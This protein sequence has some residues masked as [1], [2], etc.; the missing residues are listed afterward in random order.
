MLIYIALGANTGNRRGALLQA[1]QALDERIGPLVKC[2]SFYETE[3][4]D[5]ESEHLFLNA[6]AIFETS[7][8][9]IQLLDI[10]QDI[11]REMGRER[12]S[13]GGVH[14]DRCIDIDLLMLDRQQLHTP[15]LTLPHPHMH[16]RLFVLEPLAEIAPDLVHP[17]LGKTVRE[18]LHLMRLQQ[19][20]TKYPMQEKK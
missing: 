12:K 1:L 2:S 10:T 11:E 5:F 6:A 15:R 3:P 20:N 7:L 19:I 14:Y 13:H 18:M 16:E 4:V 9:P 17:T 8:S